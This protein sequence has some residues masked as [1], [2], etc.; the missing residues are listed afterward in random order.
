[1]LTWL[2][3]GLKAGSTQT[4]VASALKRR[5]ARPTVVVQD[6]VKE[7]R[8]DVSIG[9]KLFTSYHYGSQWVRPFLYPVVGPYGT[10]MTRNW[11]IV[12]GVKG[13]HMDHPHHKS[14]WVAYGE[15]NKVDN[16]SEEKGHGWQRHRAFRNIVSGPVVGQIVARNEWRTNKERKQFE[17]VR[18]MRFYA[19]PGGVR[20]FDIEVTFRMTEGQVVFTDTKEGG[21]VSVRVASSM[22]VRNGGRIDNAYGGINEDE[23]WGKHSPWCDYSGMTQGKHVGIAIMDHDDNPR[24]PT[25][26]HVRD[27][28]LMTANCFAWKH[29]KPEARIKGDMTFKKGTVTTWR[30]RLYVHRGDA[31]TGKV[32]ARFMDYI[33]PPKVAL[34]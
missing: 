20:L 11:P 2:V 30:Y 7:G 6:V 12:E 9:G 34:A 24:Y 26:W 15:C 22:D 5:D 14:I 17:E 18:N 3:S 19:L 1:M 33:S 25:Q 21:L 27:Y 10:Q 31:K 32:A 13:E 28:G 16:W 23:T 4:L 29:Y 8:V